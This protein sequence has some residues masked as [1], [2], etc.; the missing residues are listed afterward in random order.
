[1]D[2]RQ[3]LKLLEE[4]ESSI[5]PEFGIIPE[6]RGYDSDFNEVKNDL[7]PVARELTHNWDEWEALV[8]YVVFDDDRCDK[9]L[10][11]ILPHVEKDGLVYLEFKATQ[12]NGME[13][14][15]DRFYI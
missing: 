2:K 10:K 8:K 11:P 12:K 7:H 1:M 3:E 14:E 4:I 6:Y 15:R 13:R 9:F 5:E